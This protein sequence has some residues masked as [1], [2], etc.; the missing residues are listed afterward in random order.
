MTIEEQLSA[1][2]ATATALTGERDD[3]RATI[4]KLTVGASAELES[5]KV[6]AAAKDAKAAELSAS[7]EAM[8]AELAALKAKATDLEQSKVSASKQAAVIAAS[9]GVAPTALPVEGAATPE[10]VNHLEKF[11]SLPVGKE[12]TDYFN[13]HKA[14]IIKAAI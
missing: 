6:E 5:L 10:A 9:V 3:L 7:L 8:G 13:A 12:R 2:V 11:M 14:A 4:E 1:A